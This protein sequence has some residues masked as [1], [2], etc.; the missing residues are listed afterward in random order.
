MKVMFAGQRK[1]FLLHIEWRGIIKLIVSIFNIAESTLLFVLRERTNKGFGFKLFKLFLNHWV[2]IP[3]DKAI[4]L[5]LVLKDSHL[6]IGIVLELKVV[7]IQVIGSDIE[8]YC[9]I[10]A[11]V[12]HVI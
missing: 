3:I 10:S 5:R 6:R 12:I 11:E 9:D 2:I 8:E 7:A 1:L 4:F